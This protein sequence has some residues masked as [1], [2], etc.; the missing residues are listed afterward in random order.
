MLK[1]SS[2]LYSLS[3][4]LIAFN[5][6]IPYS[7]SQSV[8]SWVK[9]VLIFLFLE[10]L[11]Q[12]HLLLFS[13]SLPIYSFVLFCQFLYLLLILFIIINHKVRFVSD[14]RGFFIIKWGLKLYFYICLNHTNLIFWFALNYV[15]QE[16]SSLVM[17]VYGIS[18]A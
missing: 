9:V 12:L 6:Q 1:L 17:N 4:K 10:L 2:Q 14:F 11:E 15:N 3:L 16:I 18:F 8:L 7:M 5:F 13:Q